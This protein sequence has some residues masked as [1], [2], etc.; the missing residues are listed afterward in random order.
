MIAL[1][2]IAGIT[3]LGLFG[4]FIQIEPRRTQGFYARTV[5]SSILTLFFIA[6]FLLLQFA[7]GELP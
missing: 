1:R 3:S 2:I 5:C 4:L 6:A 7:L